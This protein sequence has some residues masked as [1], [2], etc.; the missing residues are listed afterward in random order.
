MIEKQIEGRTVQLF[1]A[2]AGWLHSFEKTVLQRGLCRGVIAVSFFRIDGREYCQFTTEG[3]LPLKQYV[4]SQK[5]NW[6]HG[7]EEIL[8]LLQQVIRHLLDAENHLLGPHRFTL[9]AETVYWDPKARKVRVLP[10]S[11]E[12]PPAEPDAVSEASLRNR[13]AALAETLGKRTGDLLWERYADRFFWD[14][15]EGNGG[16]LSILRQIEQA[17]RELYLHREP[18]EDTEEQKRNKPGKTPGLSESRFSI[19]RTSEPYS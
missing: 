8:L 4:E 17:K 6:N 10:F 16:L 5:R 12:G 15:R 13:F 9:T 14:I 3:L 2:E 11:E 7:G 19:F 18:E 1:P